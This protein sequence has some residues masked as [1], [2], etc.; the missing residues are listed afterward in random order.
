[1]ENYLF[2]LEEVV[3]N[4]RLLADVGGKFAGLV[5]LAE[6]L[7]NNS[8][9]GYFHFCIPKS[10]VISTRFFDFQGYSLHTDF[11]KLTFPDTLLQ[12][13][14]MIIQKCG[15]SVALRSSA[16]IEDGGDCKNPNK[17]FSGVFKSFLNVTS[18]D[19]AEKLKEIYASLYS[20]VLKEE[21]LD[22][23]KLKM[24]IIIQ[25]MVKKPKFSGVAYSR[26]ILPQT[27][28]GLCTAIH[29]VK[30]NTAEKMIVG[31]EKGSLEFVPKFCLNN[32]VDD[33]QLCTVS[34]LEKNDH[35]RY[36]R[37]HI[38]SENS[39]KKVAWIELSLFLEKL[40]HLLQYDIDLEFC[41]AENQNFYLLQQR[42]QPKSLGFKGKR[43]VS[44]DAVA[45]FNEQKSCIKGEVVILEASSST[46]ESIKNLPLPE[47]EGKI[48]VLRQRSFAELKKINAHYTSENYDYYVAQSIQLF[49]ALFKTKKYKKTKAIIDT[50]GFLMTA[51]YGHFGNDLCSCGVPFLCCEDVKQNNCLQNGTE[52]CVDFR[53]GFFK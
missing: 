51:V 6:I 3:K 27:K 41:V 45:Y 12:Q 53:Q 50:T 19:F 5:R 34:S 1:M 9:E 28:N 13:C 36:C 18:K 17:L 31:K 43:C 26:E 10:W 38:E 32:Q 39:F 20:S 48:I 37:Q 8:E 44:T 14:E 35:Y 33:F 16:N 30:N 49:F 4:H 7:A 22:L 40:E 15:G 46:A 23:Q 47:V 42:P 21:H 2:S 52:I 24:A 29:Y 25:E 11:E